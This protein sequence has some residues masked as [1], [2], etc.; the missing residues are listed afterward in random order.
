MGAAE[1][2]RFRWRNEVSD[3]PGLARVCALAVLA[4]S[5]GALA[6]LLVHSVS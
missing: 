3:V 1:H 2:T 4:L 5:Q 6:K